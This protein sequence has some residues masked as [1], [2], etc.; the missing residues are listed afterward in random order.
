M[1]VLLASSLLPSFLVLRFLLRRPEKE[2]R[3]GNGKDPPAN[4][5]DFGKQWPKTVKIVVKK[6]YEH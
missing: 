1:W 5:K 3:E 4:G 2:H 6:R